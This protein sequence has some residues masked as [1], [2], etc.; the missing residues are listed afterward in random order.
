MIL[1]LV[2]RIV[3]GLAALLP[4]CRTW[5]NVP[6]F[7]TDEFLLQEFLVFGLVYVVFSSNTCSDNEDIATGV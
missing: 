6:I 5:D 7:Y 3:Y 1:A 4:Y 2:K